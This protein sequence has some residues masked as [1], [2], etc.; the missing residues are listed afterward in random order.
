MKSTM[1]CRTNCV[2]VV[3][4]VTLLA[5]SA[6]SSLAQGWR[7]NGR[8]A[9]IVRDA[10]GSPLQGA[11][12]TLRWLE[13]PGTGPAA[14]L[15]NAKGRWAVPG[16]APGL[17]RITVEAENHITAHGRVVVPE[18]GRTRSVEVRLR[19]LDEVSPAF[20]E[21]SPF[22]I[23]EWLEKGDS[24]LAQGRYAEARVEYE[25]AVAALAPGQR[26]YVLQAMAHAQFLEGDPG[27]A[28]R[29]LRDALRYGPEDRDLRALL[30]EVAKRIGKED[31]AN[32]FLSRLDAGGEPPPAEP[33]TAA[34]G[35]SANAP[36]ARSLLPA[37]PHRSGR[38][39]TT[40]EGRGPLSGLETFVKRYG[41]TRRE[42]ESNDATPREIVLAEESFEVY[43]PDGYGPATPHGLLVWIS[44]GSFGGSERP[45]VQ[46]VFDELR[47]IFVGANDSG[48]QRPRWHRFALAL[49]AAF[50][51]QR[52]YNI[53]PRRVYVAGYSGGGRVAS[54][55]TM[56][57]PEMFQGVAAFFGCNF[58]RNIPV[59]ERPGAHWPAAFRKPR[60]D[61][62]KQIKRERRFVLL[63][64]ER[65]FNRQQ[66]RATY[67]AML[68][69]GF[70]HATY[71][72]IPG[73]DHYLGIDPTYLA[74]SL[75]I[76]DGE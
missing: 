56:L 50:H 60:R 19:S 34:A 54:S 58:Y 33:A 51:M 73:A 44:P 8:A 14:A 36:T 45:D 29:T 4:A 40:F 3:F 31:E 75:L 15:A 5:T 35:E 7:G 30:L 23:V 20:S 2:Y 27:A 28:L 21:G 70:Q 62:L 22:T 69:E 25:K 53:D 52:L 9:G 24:L 17:W 66:S 1:L 32:R 43:V 16:L 55:L 10:D 57:Y 18:S 11:T 46:A 71:L 74:K 61:S 47:V 64:G 49:E 72:E 6:T 67:E 26:P 37:E 63:T 76:L 68:E 59:P 41:A 38:Y 65:D 42:I 48:N 13:E 39:R 12:V